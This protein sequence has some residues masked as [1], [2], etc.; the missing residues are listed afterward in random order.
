MSMVAV[1]QVLPRQTLG[2]QVKSHH[3]NSPQLSLIKV[4]INQAEQNFSLVFG[5]IFWLT[6]TLLRKVIVKINEGVEV[7]NKH[8]SKK[9]SKG[10]LSLNCSQCLK[11]TQ[12]VSFRN[13]TSKR[14]T[15][16]FKSRHYVEKRRGILGQFG[17]KLSGTFLAKN[18][19]F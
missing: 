17:T 3:R 1:V 7:E 16:G 8:D 10:L 15:F 2:G 11:I 13:I 19:T 12:I 14:T 4:L 6:L 5:I 18:E 9:L